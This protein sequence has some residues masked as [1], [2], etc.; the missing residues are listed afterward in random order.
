VITVTGQTVMATC[1]RC[2]REMILGSGSVGQQLA[3][4]AEYRAEVL[5]M[6]EWTCGADEP[7]VCERCA[8]PGIEAEVNYSE[9]WRRKISGGASGAAAT[10][11]GPV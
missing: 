2:G 10:G 5:G 7:D 3:A 9:A 4:S 1:D 11:C 8:H 6:A